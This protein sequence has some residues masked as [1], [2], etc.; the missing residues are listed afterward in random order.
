M[1]RDES[2]DLT[3][4]NHF[5]RPIP[6]IRELNS[7]LQR[8]HEAIEQLRRIPWLRR[9][10]EITPQRGDQTLSTKPIR[11]YGDSLS[12]EM[13]MVVRKTWD[14]HWF[15]GENTSNKPY[16]DFAFK[17]I[18]WEMGLLHDGMSACPSCGKP[19]VH[20]GHN[21]FDTCEDC[22]LRDKVRKTEEHLFPNNSKTKPYIPWLDSV[23][24][25]DWTNGTRE[26]QHPTEVLQ[27]LRK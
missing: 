27:D 1:I 15:F 3:E 13:E 25:T 22:K 12:D 5:G 18:L 16:F 9:E 8:A 6:N 17:E 11:I 10:Q 23:V 20:F 7:D 14:G 2:I 21:Q 4:D 19:R 24:I 26:F